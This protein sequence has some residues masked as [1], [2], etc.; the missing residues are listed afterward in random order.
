MAQT[1]DGGHVF[2][3]NLIADARVGHVAVIGSE[4]TAKAVRAALDGNGRKGVGLSAE[5]GCASPVLL[6]GGLWTDKELGECRH[7]PPLEHA[8][9]KLRAC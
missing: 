3:S 5:L 7:Q 4:A 9:C 1:I 6:C 8:L 2:C